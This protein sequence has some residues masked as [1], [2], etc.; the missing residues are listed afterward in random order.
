MSF[1]TFIFSVADTGD[2][3]QLYV[4]ALR[5]DNIQHP[6]VVFCLFVIYTRI[7]PVKGYAWVFSPTFQKISNSIFISVSGKGC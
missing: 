1:T 5:K 3:Y 2:I 6:L 4:V 7:E